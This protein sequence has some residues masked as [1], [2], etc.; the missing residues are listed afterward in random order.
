MSPQPEAPAFR[1]L[2]GRY[3]PD[4]LANHLIEGVRVGHDGMPRMDL[5]VLSADA[6]IAYLK[7]LDNHATG[8]GLP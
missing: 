7:W 3:D 1:G 4:M 5:D 2:L 6:L 8:S